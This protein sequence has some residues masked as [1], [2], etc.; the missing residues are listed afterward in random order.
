MLGL[1]ALT[2]L[3]AEGV[4]ASAAAVQT[5][6]VRAE[7]TRFFLAAHWVTLH[8]GEALEHERTDAAAS[9]WR[10]WSA[11]S[12][13]AHGTPT[14]SEFAAMELGAVLGMGH[15]AADCFQ[16]DA[17][18]VEFR[19]PLLRAALAEGHARVWQ[20]REVARRCAAG[21]DRDQTLFVDRETTPYLSSLPWARF[22]SLLEAKII[23]VD[24]A[25]AEER[26]RAAALARFVRTGQS[27]EYGLK[28]IVA[29]AEAGDV[30][31]FIAMADRIAQILWLH[32]DT[33]PV[34]VRRSRAIG[35]LAN[36]GRALAMLQQ[37]ARA[38]DTDEGDA[39]DQG[40]AGDPADN[41][42]DDPAPEAH[43]CPTCHG[44]GVVTG[45]AGVFTRQPDPVGGI[46]GEAAAARRHPLHPLQRPG[47]A[48]RARRRSDGGCRTG[49][50]APG[51]TLPGALQ[52]AARPRRALPPAGPR[53]STG[54]DPRGQPRNAVA[55]PASGEDPWPMEPA[56]TEPGRVR[57]A[58]TTRL[59]VP[60]R[61]PR[62]PRAR[63]APQLS[64]DPGPPA[65]CMDAG[66]GRPCAV[67]ETGPRMEGSIPSQRCRHHGAQVAD[68][69]PA[70]LVRPGG[71]GRKRPPEPILALPDSRARRVG[72]A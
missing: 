61:P 7:A 32:G 3:D 22:E 41:D 63:Q 44:G 70:P 48:H 42:A 2:D 30:V 62:H 16:R 19:H 23:E 36:P 37:A 54:S 14:V 65:D 33:D 26:A 69:A 28:T 58:I 72:H 71:P 15:V 13:R 40:V 35:I 53:R 17:V 27:N 34:D 38:D 55:V 21:L 39:G 46:D 43:P 20:A 11:R 47:G 29:R 8:S 5:E 59:L 1:D 10:G 24:P 51:P 31:C 60:G 66:F 67:C 57:V 68:L 18:N 64:P 49:H 12:G 9:C 50:H 52:R 56:T 25:A 45:D 4:L 6:M